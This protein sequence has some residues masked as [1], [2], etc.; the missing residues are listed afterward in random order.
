[1]SWA[2]EKLREKGELAKL[3]TEW[4]SSKSTY[5]FEGSTNGN[6]D[7]LSVHD[8]GGL[9]LISGI[10]STLALIF[11]LTPL[12]KK[13]SHRLTKCWIFGYLKQRLQKVGK[14]LFNKKM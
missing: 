14:Y 1:M 4:F 2:I 6:P 11:F 5:T 3:E 13:N 7:A 10:S 8:F 9:F 12:L